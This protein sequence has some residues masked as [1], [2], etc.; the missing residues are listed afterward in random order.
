M[1]TTT[2]SV[3]IWQSEPFTND[4]C[5]TGTDGLSLDAARA[6]F[7]DPSIDPSFAKH[8]NG[9]GTTELWLSIQKDND[10]WL[11]SDLVAKR[12]YSAATKAATDDDDAERREHAMMAG[13]AFGCAGYND[14]MGY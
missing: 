13:M 6:L 7:A 1:K 9:D 14:V 12:K 10:E 8:L 3:N 2:Y 11:A 4:D 5:W